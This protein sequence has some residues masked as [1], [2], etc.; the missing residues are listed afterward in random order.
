MKVQ[1]KLTK[2]PPNKCWRSL[3]GN[4]RSDSR[5]GTHIPL[6]PSTLLHCTSGKGSRR[7]PPPRRVQEAGGCKWEVARSRTREKP[8]Q[9]I[10]TGGGDTVREGVCRAAGKRKPPRLVRNRDLEV[11]REIQRAPPSG[12][13]HTL[14]PPPR[15]GGR[16]TLKKLHYKTGGRT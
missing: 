12:R 4:L 10:E 16:V 13:E 3:A 1:Q 11:T 5:L 2:S 6:S 9:V 15:P 7:A 14:P 8:A